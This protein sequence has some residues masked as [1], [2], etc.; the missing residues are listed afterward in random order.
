MVPHPQPPPAA[1][2]PDAEADLVDFKKLREL[3]GFVLHSVPRHKALA[4]GTFVAVVVAVLIGLKVMPKTYHVETTILAQRNQVLQALSNPRR[5]VPT[6]ADAP[7]RA[8]WETV[9][10]HDNLVSLVKQTNLLDTFDS[11]RAPILKLKDWLRTAVS[12]PMDDEDRLD[13][14]VGLLEKKLQVQTGEGTVTIGIDWGDANMAYRLVDTAQQNFFETR[15]ASEVSTIA[16]AISILE[17]HATNVRD[18]IE[19]TLEEISKIQGKPRPASAGTRRAAVRAGGAPQDS[20]LAQLQ[21]MLQGKQRAISDL[22]DYRRRRLSEL[23]TQYQEQLNT[24]GKA[25]P[26]I[27]NTEQS[28]AG[29]SKESPQLLQLRKEEAEL[30]Q[31]IATR[32]G[33]GAAPVAAPVVPRQEMEA[34]RRE[35]T[36]SAGEPTNDSLE[37][38][39]ARLRIANNKYEDLVDRIE[40]ARIELD[41]ARAAF[42]Y[43]YSIVKPA[44]L[45]KK[46]AKPNA[47]MFIVAG[48]ILGVM[49]AFG[50]CTLKDLLGGRIV[51]RWQVERSL[52]LPVLVEVGRT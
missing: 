10:K 19:V 1:S 21:A 36:T 52:E 9:F 28:I 15:H 24:Y 8:A 45:P 18:S 14:L 46:P 41:S 49:M 48:V 51:E 2:H 3:I 31:E 34:M 11:S 6:E 7:T 13:A 33:A 22:E 29:L 50:T 35:A 37:Y 38:A 5:S 30:R 16:E 27:A 25:H 4:A 39:R 20:Q 44:Q 47:P 40:A 17:G 42:K 43:R 26:I 12:G 32:G 23:Q